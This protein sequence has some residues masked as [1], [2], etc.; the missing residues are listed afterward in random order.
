MRLSEYHIGYK[1]RI[2]A[3]KLDTG[4]LFFHWYSGNEGVVWSESCVF[5]KQNLVA[6]DYKI[7]KLSEENGWF[8]M[9]FV[10]FLLSPSLSLALCRPIALF[11]WNTHPLTQSISLFLYKSEIHT[12]T[13]PH[14]VTHFFLSFYIF[15]KTLPLS[16]FLSL[17]ISVS[18]SVYLSIRYLYCLTSQL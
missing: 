11:I 6:V 8:K 18:L 14:T 13:H 4:T 12:H 1:I 7:C 15:L 3:T 2:H 17:S 5:I 9:F 10:S 16:L